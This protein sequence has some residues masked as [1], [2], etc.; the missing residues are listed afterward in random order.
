MTFAAQPM[1]YFFR[2]LSEVRFPALAANPIRG[3]LGAWLR[4]KGC[5]QNCLS[6]DACPEPGVCPYAEIFRPARKISGPSGLLDAPRPFVLRTSHLN[7]AIVPNGGGFRVRFVFLTIQPSWIEQVGA[8]LR[9]VSRDGLCG[10]RACLESIAPLPP[11]QIDLSRPGPNCSRLRVH[12]HTP[13]E[14]QSGGKIVREPRFEVLF[15]RIRDRLANLMRLYGDGPPEFD[16]Q[17]QDL[18]AKLIELESSNWER[19]KAQRTR[20][21]SGESHPLGGF[22]G[23]ADYRGNLTEF[24]PYLQAA[25]WAGVGRHCVWGNGEIAVK[26][27]SE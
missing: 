10:S 27:S 16:Y 17:A 20:R 19:V 15:A 13:T 6:P 22:Q 5:L 23:W 11:I 1:D 12:F 7:R 21:T 2:A 8:A 9:L 3:A 26:R 14:L 24:L 4:Q 25:Q 18:R